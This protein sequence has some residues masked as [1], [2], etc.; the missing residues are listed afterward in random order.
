MNKEKRARL[1]R[2]RSHRGLDADERKKRQRQ[3]REKKKAEPR[4]RC[5]RIERTKPLDVVHGMHMSQWKLLIFPYLDP[6]GLVQLRRTCRTFA[7]CGDLREAIR[8]ACKDVYGTLSKR[9]WDKPYPFRLARSFKP[10]AQTL[11][12]YLGHPRFIRSNWSLHISTATLKQG[13]TSLTLMAYGSIERAVCNI[14]A[15]LRDSPNV[16]YYLLCT[17]SKHGTHLQLYKHTK[18]SWQRDPFYASCGVHWHGVPPM[19]LYAYRHLCTSPTLSARLEFE[20]QMKDYTLIDHVTET[21][22]DDAMTTMAPLPTTLM[23]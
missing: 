5:V 6:V 17:E 13:N 3:R 7:G 16:T 11:L 23:P 21:R 18:S 9:Y 22:I 1:V 10:T 19:A 15:H 12:G 2:L 4:K 20:Y 14:Y 8:Q